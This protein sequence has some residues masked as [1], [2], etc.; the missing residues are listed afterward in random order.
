MMTRRAWSAALAVA[1]VVALAGPAQARPV[2]RKGVPVDALTPVDM[3]RVS[4]R[5][6][7]VE[8]QPVRLRYAVAGADEPSVLVDVVVADSAAAAREAVDLYLHQLSRELDPVAGVGDVAYGS[9]TLLVFAEDNIMIAVRRVSA[10][11]PGGADVASIANR[12]VVAV[13]AAPRGAPEV[14][15]VTAAVPK[16]LA[17]KPQSLTLSRAVLAA[18]LR[19]EGPARVL[20]QGAAWTIARTG[21]GD[22][23]V[24]V[25]AV[26]ELLRVIR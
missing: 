23:R 15:A 21:E 8:T 24:R 20:E 13:K 6:P 10:G 9:D 7:A 12:A 14:E 25:T 16:S 5:V 22:V 11:T 2:V 26:D 18:D 3:E 19:V 4:V 17:R 1:A